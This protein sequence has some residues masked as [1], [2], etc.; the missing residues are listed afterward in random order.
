MRYVVTLDSESH[1][2]SHF[3]A[4]GSDGNNGGQPTIDCAEIDMTHHHFMR[5][6]RGPIGEAGKHQSI[7]IPYGSILSV[8]EYAKQ[9]GKPFGFSSS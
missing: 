2:G 8:L 9:E 6:L 7:Y 5:V 4:V 3:R 1:I